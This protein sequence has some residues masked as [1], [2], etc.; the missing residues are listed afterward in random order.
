M[1][2]EQDPTDAVR[3]AN[4]Y[5]HTDGSRRAD[6]PLSRREARAKP[7][8]ITERRDLEDAVKTLEMVVDK[9][10][11]QARRQVGAEALERVRQACRQ[12]LAVD[13]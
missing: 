7:L 6:A 3:R 4:K 12:A 10:A 5:C 8:T 2:R 13:L 1:I 11:N 9:V